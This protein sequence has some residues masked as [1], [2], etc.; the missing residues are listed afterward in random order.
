[1][2]VGLTMF[3]WKELRDIAIK[4]NDDQIFYILGLFIDEAKAR[5]IIDVNTSGVV[6]SEDSDHYYRDFSITPEEFFKRQGRGY[7]KW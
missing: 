3:D 5:G 4:A 7:E 6:N 1:M 2:S